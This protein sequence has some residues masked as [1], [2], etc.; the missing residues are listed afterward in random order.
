MCLGQHMLSYTVWQM[1]C[2]KSIF[3]QYFQLRMAL[4]EHHHKLSTTYSSYM[5]NIIID[6]L[7]GCLFF[8]KLLA[9]NQNHFSFSGNTLLFFVVQIFWRPVSPV[10]SSLSVLHF[11]FHYSEFKLPRF[12]LQNQL[13]FYC[14]FEDNISLTL[15]DLRFASMFLVPTF[16]H[17]SYFILLKAS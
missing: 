3:D 9:S 15:T 8:L 11:S 16:R 6:L 17:S 2:V 4:L 1:G 12:T 10:F 7:F 5:L 13:Q 14:S